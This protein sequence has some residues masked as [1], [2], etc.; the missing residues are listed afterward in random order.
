MKRHSFQDVLARLFLGYA[1]IT[2]P[3]EIAAVALLF[4]VFAYSK[5]GWSSAPGVIG[6]SCGCNWKPSSQPPLSGCHLHVQPCGTRAS[7][8]R[9][10]PDVSRGELARPVHARK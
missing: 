5:R 2:A 7:F 9:C 10:T 4:Y 6:S 8:S 3:L 1:V